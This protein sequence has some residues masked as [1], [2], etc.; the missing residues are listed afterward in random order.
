MSFRFKPDDQDVM[1]RSGRC[2]GI[3]LEKANALLEAHEKTLP[4]INLKKTDD[5]E[6]FQIFQG[7]TDTA[8]LWDVK[9]VK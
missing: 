9:E 6:Y 1:H 3:S 2:R 5:G 8:L 4:R 7:W